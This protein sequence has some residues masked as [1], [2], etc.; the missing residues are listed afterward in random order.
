LRSGDSAAVGNYCVAGG[1]DPLALVVKAGADADG[2]EDSFG[3]GD[4]LVGVL[5]D[6]VGGEAQFFS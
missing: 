6:E 5:D 1:I 3:G 4:N 2:A